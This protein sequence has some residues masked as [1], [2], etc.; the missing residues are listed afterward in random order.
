MRTS[1]VW[2][3][4]ALLTFPVCFSA[5]AQKPPNVVFILVDDMGWRDLGCYGSDFYETPVIDRLASEG[6]RFTQAYQSAPNCAPSRGAILTGK[7]PARTGFTSV[8]G[9]GI[10]GEGAKS[11]DRM[12]PPYYPGRISTDEVLIPEAL[13]ANGYI[14]GMFGKWH[15]TCGH[16][17]SPGPLEQGFDTADEGRG[18]TAHPGEHEK[19]PLSY[20][21]D[22][23]YN[24]PY[25]QA[26][27]FAPDSLTENACDFIRRNQDR[28][29]FLYVAH[30]MVHAPILSKNLWL[31]EHF[32][33]KAGLPPCTPFADYETPGQNNP[34]YAAMVATV[35]WSVGR[36][37]DQLKA[38]GLADNTIVILSSDNGGVTNIGNR[39]GKMNVTS[40]LPLRGR[41]SELWEGGIRVPLIVRWPGRINPGTVSDVP[42]TGVDF[43]PT[44]LE[45]TGTPRPEAQHLDGYSLVPL[46][47]AGIPP[48]RE[49]LFW[50]FPHFDFYS[51]VQHGPF[52]LIRFH[53]D[54]R[55]ELYK[56]DGDIGEQQ[57]CSALFP[58]MSAMLSEKLDEWLKQTGAVMPYRN[59]AAERNGKPLVA[60]RG[61]GIAGKTAWVEFEGGL[62]V[63]EVNLIYT[64]YKGK[65]P[66]F[67]CKPAT[68]L[69]GRA[70][71]ELPEDAA[72]CYWNLIDEERR[73]VLSDRWETGKPGIFQTLKRDTAD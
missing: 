9:G 70:E 45:M 59:P 58:E 50:H 68:V 24:Q 66:E 39:P 16:N 5:T 23:T 4:T 73:L 14:T 56:L 33:K 65:Q 34:T 36:I 42:V 7:W 47:T 20:W 63:R 17:A 8:S 13:K 43:Y 41:K 2:K 64:P 30:W 1:D 49:F 54:G 71:I 37:L 55:T 26:G 72:V 52:K 22:Y 61:Q 51:A 38:C 48:K 25:T 35:D 27:E 3:N 53:E 11:R 46:L 57:E 12:I 29:F 10:P 6:V 28:P 19:H 67:F 15:L 60:I 69:D 32:R 31:V 62:T 44:I 40:N 18:C 21:V